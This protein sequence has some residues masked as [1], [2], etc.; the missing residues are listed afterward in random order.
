MC[1]ADM[2]KEDKTGGKKF[3]D[4]GGE[5]IP[6]AAANNI[7]VGGLGRSG[8]YAHYCWMP[9]AAATSLSL[10]L[11]SAQS[12][13]ESLQQ[14]VA[15]CLLA[16][17][18]CASHPQTYSADMGYPYCIVLLL[19]RLHLQVNAYLFDGFWED[20]GTIKSFFEENLKLAQQ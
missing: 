19:L 14:Q 17:L 5:I 13:N 7:K 8:M 11:L 4:F 15:V 1:A 16:S 20:I 2:L 6:F 10:C 18:P 9:L 3:M 12:G